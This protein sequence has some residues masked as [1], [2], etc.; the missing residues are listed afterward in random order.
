MRC[1]RLSRE[2]GRRNRVGYI[3]ARW[4]LWPLALATAVAVVAGGSQ[5]FGGGYWLDL[6]EYQC[7]AVA[8]WHGQA[9]LQSL[10]AGQCALMQMVAGA[11]VAAQ[12]FQTL[13]R[14]YG[15][16]ALALFSPPL[17]APVAWYPWLFTGEMVLIMLAT[18]WLCARWGARLAGHAYLLYVLLGSAII[19]GTRFDAAPALLTLLAVIWARREHRGPAYAV[20]AAA[21]LVKVY[22]LALLPLFLVADLRAVAKGGWRTALRGLAIYTGVLALGVG[23]ALWLNPAGALGPISFLAQRGIEFESLPG[24]LLW[25]AHVGVGVA[26]TQGYEANVIVL[27]SPLAGAASAVAA[28]LG[29][30]LM[31]GAVWLQWRGRLTLGR[32][33]V[34]ALLGV[35]AASKV[36]SAQYVLW[37]APLV[38]LELGLDVAWSAAW[39]A[40]C[41]LT[42]LAFPVAYDD[43]F[44][45]L[46]LPSWQAVVWV[47]GARNVALALLAGGLLWRADHARGAATAVPTEGTRRWRRVELLPPLQK[48]V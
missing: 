42:L 2:D 43:T 12:P 3:L 11:H 14:E 4:T 1:T 18:A 22:P 32:A 26:L 46:G 28:L 25:L 35:L 29:L 7:Y 27:A 36:F 30:G 45:W 38:A 34:V 41:L 23:L 37:V 9:G 5:S 6:Y 39:G 24:T 17:L 31:A 40:V 44:A 10:P 13:P 21:T 8:F 48:S 19:A 33:C 16:L 15:A 47:S 20:L